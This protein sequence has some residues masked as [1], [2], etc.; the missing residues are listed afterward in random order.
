MVVP[1]GSAPAEAATM[2]NLFR[3]KPQSLM[4]EVLELSQEGYCA[5][6]G[7][8]YYQDSLRATGELC[9]PGPEGRPTFT[10]IL[11]AEPENIYDANAI[12]IYSPRGKLGHLSREDAVAYRPV[13]DEFGRL[14]YSGASCQAYLTGGQPDKPSFGVVLRLSAP[15]E[16]LADLRRE[17]PR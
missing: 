7:E 10:A 5:V 11:A 8:S 14:G 6:V 2:L 13:F 4:L 1:V 9:T 12:A 16:C 15:E 3:K 17:N